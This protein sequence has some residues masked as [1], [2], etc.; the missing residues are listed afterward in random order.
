MMIA[1]RCRSATTRT[2]EGRNPT[3]SRGCRFSFLGLQTDLTNQAARPG[4]VAIAPRG[5]AARE[6]RT[7][8]IWFQS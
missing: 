1:Q 7:T 8:F 5:E 2:L 6:S 4:S 3:G